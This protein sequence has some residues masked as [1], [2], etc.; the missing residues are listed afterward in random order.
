MGVLLLLAN[1]K[2]VCYEALEEILQ[3]PVVVD[4]DLLAKTWLNE[5]SINT[6]V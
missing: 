6:N 5:A 3:G 4:A 2:S 1:F